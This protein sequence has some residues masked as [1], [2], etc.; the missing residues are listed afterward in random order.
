MGHKI[1]KISM[2][3]KVIGRYWT[4][5]KNSLCNK[6][7]RNVKFLVVYINTCETSLRGNY[8]LLFKIIQV[9][10]TNIQY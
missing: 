7:S 1:Y 8:S 4:R 2:T 9:S 5:S 3:I 10:T 6:D